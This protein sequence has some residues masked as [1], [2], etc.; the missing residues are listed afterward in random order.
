MEEQRKKDNRGI[1]RSSTSR[2]EVR[3][4]MFSF[5]N[6]LSDSNIENC[7]RVFWL[8][9]TRLEAANMWELGKELGVTHT[10]NEDEI[11]SRLIELENR[12][13]GQ[14]TGEADVNDAGR[15]IGDQ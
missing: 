8:N 13:A 7:N 14:N 15:T 11:L 2:K 10:G 12:D 6:S 3:H 9:N 1:Q 5:C 4:R